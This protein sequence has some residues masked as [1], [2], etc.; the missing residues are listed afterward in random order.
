MFR[1]FFPQGYANPP[2]VHKKWTCRSQWRFGVSVAK[3]SHPP[4][5]R[6]KEEEEDNIFS[7]DRFFFFFLVGMRFQRILNDP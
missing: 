4:K 6:L 2:T 5:C 3:A 1:F 7:A